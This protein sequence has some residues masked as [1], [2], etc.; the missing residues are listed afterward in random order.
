MRSTGMHID[1]YTATAKWLHWGMAFIWLG[2]WL[3]GFAAVHARGLNAD[4]SVTFLHK[5]LAS[6]VLFLVILRVAWRL[7]HPAPA[8]PGEMSSL[9]RRAA[10]LGHVAL[11][12]IALFA[13]PL[14]GWLWSSLA[15]KPIML[16]GLVHLPPLTGPN[17]ALYPWVEAFHTYTA[18]LCGALVGGHILVALKH[19]FVD[20]DAVLRG[21]LPK[22]EG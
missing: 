13:L 12:L 18:W 1:H 7:T 3:L 16:L 19:H 4:H 8:L 5:V 22:T 10:H 15:A 2:S 6:T 11:Y 21:M 14:S 20:K 17:P 9:M